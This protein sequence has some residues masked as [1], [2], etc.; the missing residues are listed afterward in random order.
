MITAFH[1]SQKPAMKIA[2]PQKSILPLPPMP[3]LVGHTSSWYALSKPASTHSIRSG[4]SSATC[5]WPMPSELSKVVM[6][7]YIIEPPDL[8]VIEGVNIRPKQ[9]YFLRSGDILAKRSKGLC[10]MPRY[11][12]LSGRSR[13]RY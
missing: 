7:D 5:S 12:E 1:L 4:R 11:P 9:P 3:L 13:K 8:L 10:P 2:Y 6:P